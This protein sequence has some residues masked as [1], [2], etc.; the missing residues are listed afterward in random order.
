VTRPVLEIAGLSVGFQTATGPRP[1]LDDVTL[2]VGAGE[3]V[4]LIGESGC[5]KTTL[6]RAILGMLPTGRARLAQGQ[7][8][9]G[10]VD[11]LR[12]EGAARH[13]RGRT[14][15]LIPQDTL[16]SFHP[17]FRVGTQIV[18]LMRATRPGG[19]RS[20]RSLEEEA[21]E[22]LAAVQL[23]QPREM[24]AR[25]PHQLSGGQRQRLL[26]AM[27]LL[28]RPRIILADEPT[29]ALDTV[30]QAQILTTLRRLAVERGAA[31]LFTTHNLG[32]AWEMCDRIS[33]MLAGGIVE[34]ASRD[35]LFAA[36]LHPYTRL[37]L[38]S[39]PQ[40]GR[41]VPG[42]SGELSRPISDVGCPFASRCPNASKICW[43][44]RPRLCDNG[45]GHWV[46]CH[47]PAAPMPHAERRTF[48]PAGH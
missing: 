4:G 14:V 37:L 31:V 7:I 2:S 43:D 38:A 46:A 36:A 22:A 32:I 10:G 12:D 9:L 35:V 29:S 11:L 39:V 6:T 34:V 44:A 41:A 5:G 30:V 19:G 33:V 42:R 3:I 8:R 1:V 45:A 47:H 18:D 25:R 17:L 23:P 40:F 28:P 16:A 13:A 15:T 27:A 26:I 24:L 20:R 21:I 48:A